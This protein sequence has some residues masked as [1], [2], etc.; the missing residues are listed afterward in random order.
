MIL[1][2]VCGRCKW[3]EHAWNEH[4]KEYGDW[5]CVNLE[6]ECYSDCTPYSHTCEDW[7]EI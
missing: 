3:H 7:E 5:F 4:A 1:E 2:E 6:S